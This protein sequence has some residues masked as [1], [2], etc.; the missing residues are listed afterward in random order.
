MK[1]NKLNELSRR[2][3]LA[4]T[5]RTCFGVT[6]GGSMANL[7][8]ASAFAADPAVVAAGGGKAK[9]LIYLF[10][11]GGMS[12]IDTFDPKPEAGSDIMG[13]TKAIKT[14]VDGIQFGSLL[15]KLAQQADKMALIRS[16]NSTQGA[17]GPGR[18]FMRTGYAQRA[19]IVHP[20]SAAWVNKLTSPMND[21]LPG[22]VTINCNNDHPGAG[23]FEPKFQPLPVEKP[24]E[25][26]KNSHQRKEVT[27]SEFEKQLKLRRILDA[28]FDAKYHEGHKET[29]AYNEIYDSAVR[30]MKSEDLEAFDLS[31]EPKEVHALYGATTFSKGCLLARR[32][33]E[34][35]VRSIEVELG[36][37]DWHADNFVE[38]ENKLPIL[39]QALSALL[40]DL[41]A[42][43]LLDSTLVVLATEFGRTP[44][45]TGNAGRNHFPKAFTTLMAGGGIKGGMAYGTTDKTAAEVTENK[46]NAGDF[47]AT[48][49]HAMG[50]KHDQI[51]YSSSKRPF[52]MGSQHGSP[53]QG[54]FA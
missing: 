13:E 52:K 29:R 49:A 18:Y 42:K 2:D 17:H 7:F 24:E 34:R 5:A 26:L 54:I 48:I 21:T 37:F 6:I 23:F 28:E 44:K 10:M 27:D 25:G 8:S 36:G 35:G 15:P 40:I 43:G 53:I 47:N 16:M 11:S 32:L 30:L 45:V 46:V 33:V 51:V 3:F 41:K 50:L 20:S 31:N 9:H 1:S 39:D 12:H 22:F 38:A 14:N 4:T 19:S